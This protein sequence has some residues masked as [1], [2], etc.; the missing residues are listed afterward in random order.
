MIQAIKNVVK[1]FAASIYDIF[2]SYF[3]TIAAHQIIINHMHLTAGNLL[4]IGCGTGAPL[5]KIVSQITKF[6]DKIVGIDMNESYVK[7]ALK[8]FKGDEKVSIYNMNFYEIKQYLQL[9][10]RFIF[11]SF[12]FMLMPDQRKAL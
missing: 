5:K 2:I 11:F 6:Q 7:N 10:Y 1:L 4:D 8:L 9:K 12:S 3:F